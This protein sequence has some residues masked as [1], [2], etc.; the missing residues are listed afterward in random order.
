VNAEAAEDHS[1]GFGHSPV[2]RVRGTTCGMAG[3]HRADCP[4]RPTQ[5]TVVPRRA[6]Q[7]VDLVDK[8]TGSSS[9]RSGIDIRRGL[10]EP[11]I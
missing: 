1:G 7:L 9:H 8:Q 5:T 2:A 10:L 6:T 3:L 11:V 4:T